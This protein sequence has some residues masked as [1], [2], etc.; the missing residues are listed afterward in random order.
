MNQLFRLARIQS[1]INANG[2]F[3]AHFSTENPLG[4][5]YLLGN[6]ATDRRATGDCRLISS[7]F[8]YMKATKSPG[9]SRRPAI[10]R[11][12]TEEPSGDGP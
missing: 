5:A 7:M 10:G 4:M 11:S 6:W 2:R 9:D 8:D 3:S 1:I 12:A